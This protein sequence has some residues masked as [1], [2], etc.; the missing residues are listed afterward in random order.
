M[1]ESQDPRAPRPQS[2]DSRPYLLPSVSDQRI[3]DQLSARWREVPQRNATLGDIRMAAEIDGPDQ[4]EEATLVQPYDRTAV[5]GLDPATLRVF[6]WHPE[7]ERLRP[8][9]SSGVNA[10]LQRVWARVR[11]PGVYVPIGLPRDR[12]L[13]ETLRAIAIQRRSRDIQ[14][15]EE[16]QSIVESRLRPLLELPDEALDELRAYLARIEIGQS[17][18]PWPTAAYR[19]RPTHSMA[20]AG[21]LRVRLT[22]AAG[23]GRRRGP[24]RCQ[25]PAA[26]R[27]PRPRIR[28]GGN[29]SD[30]SPISIAFQARA[31]WPAFTS[32]GRAT[33]RSSASWRTASVIG[34]RN[35]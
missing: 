2:G 27:A 25:L 33:P 30:P 14:D 28:G 4:F 19:N 7:D 16:E 12:L 9:W 29:R 10:S 23:R 17:V 34:S 6:R 26:E 18:L 22:A 21:L 5:S 15:P 24:T 20:V 35:G 8:V 11:R 31:T 32:V 1:T 13:F 3:A